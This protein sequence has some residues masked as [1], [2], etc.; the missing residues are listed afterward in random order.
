MME[1]NYK[2]KQKLL[3]VGNSRAVSIPAEWLKTQCKKLG[4]KV[5]NALDLLIYDDYLE[6]HVVKEK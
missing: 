3:K 1:K 4:I 6:I 5:I 2:Y